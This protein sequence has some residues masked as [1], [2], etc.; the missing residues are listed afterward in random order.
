[1]ENKKQLTEVEIVASLPEEFQKL[2]HIALA[3]VNRVKAE[4]KP[5]K[6]EPL[7]VAPLV[8]KLEPITVFGGNVLSIKHEHDS[9][10]P[11]RLQVGK[12]EAV[13]SSPVSVSKAGNRLIIS[14]VSEFVTL[15][16]RKPEFQ[17]EREIK[18]LVEF[19]NNIEHA[20]NCSKGGLFEAA[21]SMYGHLL[22]ILE[23][24]NPNF[25]TLL[26]KDVGVDWLVFKDRDHILLEI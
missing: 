5:R 1:M 22:P 16:K 18:E 11:G 9:F 7:S 12:I 25:F 21:D 14:N 19:I 2:Y 23:A 3:D 15:V 13:K 17:E 6:E 26:K 8:N 4:R 24:R 10:F 20:C